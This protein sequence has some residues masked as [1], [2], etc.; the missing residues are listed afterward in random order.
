MELGESRRIDLAHEAAFRLG[1][2]R[3]D[4]PLRA[5]RRDDGAE[6]VVE[7]RV[8][9]VLVALA[10]AGGATLSRDD[11]IQRCWEGRVVGDDAI[12]RVISRLRRSAEGIGQGSFHIETLTKV[13]YRLIADG[14]AP[15]AT[16]AAQP[17]DDA[18][19]RLKL[20]R[21]AM[22]AGSGLAVVT[23]GGYALWRRRGH[24]E[25]PPP[26]VAALM[27]QASNALA[28]GTADGNSQGIGLLRRVVELRPDYAEGWGMLALAYRASSFGGRPEEEAPM[29][30]RA[31]AAARRAR[32]L[33]PDNVHARLV[34]LSKPGERANRFRFEQE[35]RTALAEHP[36]SD[37]LMGTLGSILMGV[38]R[39][40]DAAELMDR[41]LQVSAPSPG[42]VYS[43]AQ[44][45]WAA[46]RLEEADAAIEEAFALYPTHFAV[47]FT[48]FYLL[49]YTGR[50]DQAETQCRNRNGRPTNIPAYNFE[51][52]LAVARAMQTRAP[53]DIDEAMRLSLDAARKGAG[54]CENAMQFASALGRVDRAFEIAGAYYFARGFDPGEVRFS[55]QQRS[56]TRRYARRTHMLFFPSTAAMRADRRFAEITRS[57]GLDRYW[58]DSG[59]LPDYRQG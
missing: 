16:A 47:W 42:L 37:M 32:E 14:L 52:L 3:A 56:Y 29:R 41:A 30:A 26:E 11:L 17:G 10:A 22:L 45:L 44:T 12:N 7:P 34:D 39:C 2:L 9:Q 25:A 46:G 6:E 15:A 18:V 53:R 23:V 55:E 28:Q 19:R 59:V 21:R 43:R 50:A 20:D 48:R 58:Q 35:L 51:M 13:G 27:T 5:L 38:G 24:D 33:D 54:H 49:L 36:T 57:Q 40:R 31:L 4:P 1:V 8:M